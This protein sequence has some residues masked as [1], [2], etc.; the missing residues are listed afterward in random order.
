M[1]AIAFTILL[2]IECNIGGI[3]YEQE[4]YNFNNM[5]NY[6]CSC[7]GNYCCC[8]RRYIV[9]SQVQ[10]VGVNSLSVTA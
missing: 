1:I 5:F 2:R 6:I 10:K 4:I 3:Q 7:L 9:K 8:T